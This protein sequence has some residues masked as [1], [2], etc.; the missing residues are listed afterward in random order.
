MGKH[1]FENMKL[2]KM[3]IF[4]SLPHFIIENSPI[5]VI[6]KF[7]VA[8]LHDVT[9]FIRTCNFVLMILFSVISFDVSAG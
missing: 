6:V 1:P 4:I 8:V 2:V 3:V 7:I 5:C 9:T